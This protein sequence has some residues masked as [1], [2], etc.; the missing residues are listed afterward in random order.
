MVVLV[1]W[2]VCGVMWLVYWYD[3]GVVLVWHGV[4]WCGIVVWLV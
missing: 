3:C 4:V 2:Y 1:Y